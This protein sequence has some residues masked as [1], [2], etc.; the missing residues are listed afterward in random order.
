MKKNFMGTLC[1]RG[2]IE[3][4]LKIMKLTTFFIFMICV[5]LHASVYSQQ[6]K[7]SL[8]LNN[9]DISTV[10]SEIEKQSDYAFTYPVDD[11]S[12]A[13]TISI[14]VENALID[15]VMHK[16]LNVME[17]SYSVI[18]KHIIITKKHLVSLAKDE[19]EITGVVKDQE[20]YPLPGVSVTLKSNPSV[21]VSTDIDGKFS[22]KVSK[23]KKEVLVFS[24]VGMKTVEIPV[25]AKSAYNVVL[26]SDAELLEE[27]VISTGFQKIDRRLFTGSA[28][29]V[30]AEDVK[31]EGVL[32]VGRMLEGQAAGVSVQNV[33]GTFGTAPKIRVRGASSIYGD[34]KPLWVVDGVVLEDVVNV[35]ADELSSGD[36]ATLVSSAVAGLNADDIEDFQVLKDASATALYGARAM[37]GVIVIT[38][39]KGKKGTPKVT[40]STNMTMRLKPVYSDY[41]IM[42]S[43]DQM[44]VY[45]EMER[46]G[47]LNH[48]S[49]SRSKNGGVF[50]KMYDRINTY[51][52]KS[53]SFLLSNTPSSKAQFL[54]QYE[55][56]NTDW[57]NT[58]FNTS[59][60]Q[61]HAL[62]ISSGTD[63]SQTYFSASYYHDNGW[64]M[65]SG[66]DRYTANLR[67][68]FDLSEKLSAGFTCVGS[69][70]EQEAPGTVNR[71]SNVVEGSYNRDFDI[72]PFSY[73]LNTSRTMR[74]YDENG[75]LEYFRRNYSPFNIINEL[76]N[77]YID[78]NVL[79]LKLQADLNYKI[80]TGLEYS[81]VGSIR[82]VKS[83]REHIITENS[84]M[85]NSYRMASSSTIREA[86]NL[87][88]KN[89]D[90]PN[91]EPVVVLP[92]G[93]FYNRNE[94]YLKNYY[95]RNSL[96][97]NKTFNEIHI[98]NILIGQDL[99]YVDRQS[100]VNEGPGYQYNRGGVP[101]IDPNYY[102]QNLELGS[103]PFSMGWEYDRYVAAFFNGSYSYKGKYTFNG[104][105]RVDGSNQLGKK[106]SSRYLP[107]WN[108]SGAWNLHT[109]DFLS[110]S[111]I[112][113]RLTLRGTYG[114]NASM[115]P[116]RNSS[117][118][119]MN[120]T[121]ERPYIDEKESGIEIESLENS[122]L[123]WEKQYEA[124]VGFDLGLLNNRINITV[125][126]Y[127]RKSF[128]LIGVINTSGIGGEGYKWANYADMKSHGVEFSLGTTNVKTD[129]FNWSSNFTFAYNTN[130]ITNLDSKPRI[131][132]L[133]KPEGGAV[134]G[135]SVRSLFS[136]PFA[137][138]SENGTPLF[139]GSDG[140]ITDKINFQSKNI[141]FLKYEGSI[142]PK[143][144][145]GLTNTFGYKRWKVNAFVSYQAGNKIRL[146]PSFGSAYS[147]VDAMSKEFN[148]RWIISGDENY[149]NIPTIMSKRQN[150][151]LDGNYP[152]SY[153]NF[154]DARVA[155]GDFVRLKNVSVSYLVPSSVLKS[156][157]IKSASIKFQ[158]TNLWLIYSDSKLKGQDPEFFG[159]GG[160]A[161]PQPKQ[162]TFSLKLDF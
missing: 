38:T 28:A 53:N 154:S 71:T 44:S 59:L 123:T 137:G 81:F 67:M 115:G 124:N 91:A 93:G 83:A 56:A 119:L 27:V 95:F 134:K 48:A 92:K 30:K 36:A 66:V 96:N 131:S 13:K 63:F 128:D 90:T 141:D 126:A 108:L 107:T 73:A 33:S 144:V 54:K 62:S 159:A 158:A 114:M 78:L 82:Y 68:N 57:F 21:G 100:F 87:L 145:G 42:N 129:D 112:I 4:A 12:L 11:I 135:Y 51:D 133:V 41:N 120:A 138:L 139:Y 88:Y 46:K 47:W 37:N 49:I 116:A 104:T 149:T 99:K 146:N 61:E 45:L 118:I 105:T 97:W 98:V 85:A 121:T 156:L 31:V 140:K 148:D 76:N 58:L 130:E 34:Q 101:F 23:K 117:L 55:T 29:K 84:N 102:K 7:L 26:E 74:A 89:P 142:D 70:R 125:D 22:I 80:M 18:D 24:F 162:F 20:G 143:V 161:L 69:I 132:S 64:A 86:N 75:N 150:S 152:Y 153:Y 122:E 19:R 32:D 72:N 136:I 16:C 94:D 147:D 15:E 157:K 79:D 50:S 40:Y 9:V 3:K 77:N 103:N 8:K 106:R 151:L 113:S 60:A 35:S 14:S 43:Q 109:E 6:T 10:F 39:K 160:V 110:K 2:K 52:E 1:P 111:E 17:F 127:Q 25:G 65:K 155:D 5:Q